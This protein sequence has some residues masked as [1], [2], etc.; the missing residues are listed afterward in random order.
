MWFPAVVGI[1]GCVLLAAGAGAIAAEPRAYVVA[2]PPTEES[3][4]F[5]VSN[6]PPLLPS[7]FMK[8][9]IGAI[10]PQGWL[11]HQLE[12]EADGMTGHLPELS[13]WC[14]KEISAWMSPSGEGLFGW[15]ELPY[16]LKGFGDLGYVLGDERIV[17]EAREWIDAILSSQEEDGWFAPRANKKGNDMWPNM[18]ALNVLQSFH[19]YTGDERVLPL[20]REYFRWQLAVPED[21][22]LLGSWQKIRAGDNLESI[23]WLYNRTG[24]KWLLDLGDRLHRRTANWTEAFPTWHGVNICQSFRQPAVYYEQSRD[25]KHLQATEKRYEEVMKLYGQM[26]GG[27]FGADE[28]ARRGYRDPRQAAETCSIVEF[29][30]SDQMLLKITG[31]VVYADRCEDVAFNSFPASQPPDQKGLH[32]LT[33]PNM[34]QLDR[35]NKSPG[36]QN[37]GCM[38]AYDPW[39]YRCCQHNV[40]HGWPYYAEHLWL[41]TPG[42]GLAAVLYAACTVT[43]KVG[44]GNGV[45][46]RIVEETDYPFGET[47]VLTL[48]APNP[49][50][51]PLYVRIPGWCERANATVNAKRVEAKPDPGTYLVIE[52]E[53]RDGDKVV[54]ELPMELSV[55]VWEQNQDAVSVHRGPLAYSLKIGERWER[56]AGTDEWPAYE[57]FP[58]TPWNY[59]LVLDTDDPAR[60]FDVVERKGALP[61]QPFTVDDA[62]VELVA[63]GKRIPNWQLVRGL[64]STLQSSPA[65]SGEPVEQIR[66]IPMGCARLRI[67]AFPVIGE[68]PDAHEWEAPPPTRH[69]ASFEHDDIN[70]LSDGRLPENSNDHSIP[71]FTWWNH[72]GT[73]EWVTWRFDEPREVSE[74]EV[75]WFDDTGVGRCRVPASWAVLWRDG[76][77]WRP[78]EATSGYGCEPDKFNRVTFD[79]VTTTELKLVVQLQPDVSGGI[80]EWRVGGGQ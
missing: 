69:E 22:L 2:T 10:E 49:V 54:L 9:P 37:A 39:S 13:R 70:A 28:N 17:N 24:D 64:C 72:L 61:L 48:G 45:E 30:H 76:E 40:S 11:R 14:N 46:V 35:Q 7:P 59:G 41:A 26:P 44:G 23:H 29:M 50:T 77:E 33:A 58:T 80:L 5:Y 47:V 75:Y 51:F 4:S 38:L 27:M 43:A 1:G 36:L 68:G 63:K 19:E 42:N 66:L 20:M 67:S 34:P 8:L 74:C 73:E 78:V 12:L 16:W 3:N 65:K 53:W 62:P 32:Y 6:R 21:Q 52:R 25:P 31:Q 79:P 55:K 18:I 56:Y 57:V 60:S 15:E 71:R